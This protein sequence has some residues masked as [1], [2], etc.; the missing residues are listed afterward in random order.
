MVKKQGIRY[1]AFNSGGREVR[2]PLV[3]PLMTSTAILSVVGSRLEADSQRKLVT[4]GRQL[5][6]DLHLANELGELSQ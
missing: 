1:L 6:T 5:D 2:L 4:I 3:P